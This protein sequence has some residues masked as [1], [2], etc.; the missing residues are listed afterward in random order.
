MPPDQ[1][2]FQMESTLL[3]SSPVSMF[4]FFFDS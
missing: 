3:R 4:W 1:K 2:A